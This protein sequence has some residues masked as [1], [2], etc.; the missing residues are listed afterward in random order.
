MSSIGS[1]PASAPGG[2]DGRA[3]GA[4]DLTR[5]IA[6]GET[7]VSDRAGVGAAQAGISLGV[8]LAVV[9][10]VAAVLIGVVVTVVVASLPV[11]LYGT[12]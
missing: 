9:V 4:D 5:L 3:A 6:E 10:P 7:E 2:D 8:L 11:L 1:G 12:P